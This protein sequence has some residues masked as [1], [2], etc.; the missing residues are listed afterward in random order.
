[1]YSDNRDAWE[2]RAWAALTR[3]SVRSPW[4]RLHTTPGS[5]TKLDFA[6]QT[7]LHRATAQTLHAFSPVPS[8]AGTTTK[9]GFLPLA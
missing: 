6:K 5:T 9:A 3:Q 2:Q 7:E 1:M 4:K 8:R